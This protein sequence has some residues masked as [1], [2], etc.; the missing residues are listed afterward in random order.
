MK[1][2]DSHTARYGID[3]L[4]WYQEYQDIQEA[5]GFEKENQMTK[6]RKKGETNR[7]RK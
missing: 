5:I 6:E 2:Y 7:R 3:R 4:V 1:L